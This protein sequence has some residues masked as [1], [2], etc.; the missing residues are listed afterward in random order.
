MDYTKLPR[1]LIYKNR[2]DLK[3][4]GVQTPDTMNYLLFMY[5]KQ[6]ALMGVPGA[7]EVALKCYNNAYYICTIIL[8][9][10]NDF[11]ELRISDYVD[12]ILE[13][14]K[15]NKYTDEVCLASMAMACLLLARYD[16]KYG[17]NS[18]IWKAIYHRCTHYQWYH[19]PTTE[20]FLNM[21]SLEYSFSFP[22]S[23][24]EFEPRNI[25]EAI[26]EASPLD[27]A[28]GHKYICNS[29][30]NVTDRRKAIYAA[31]L[32]IS[33]LN[34]NLH[35]I[36]DNYGYNPDTDR[37]EYNDAHV[38]DLNSELRVRDSIEIRKYAV[39]YIT[40]HFPT[41]ETN[42][43]EN[44]KESQKADSKAE[45]DYL[46]EQIEKLRREIKD[47]DDR[48]SITQEQLDAIFYQGEDTI[49]N[50][51]NQINI[52]ENKRELTE[53]V[54]QQ[55][56]EQEQEIDRL[57]NDL[58]AFKTQNGKTRMTASQAAI[59]LLTV[60]HNLRQL[61]NDKKKLTP[62]LE[63]GW[64]FTETTASR[65]L[66]SKPSQKVADETASIFESVSPKLARLIKEFPQTF[67]EIRINKLKAN[68][69][70]KLKINS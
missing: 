53:K 39:E 37:F 43:N 32:A 13:T 16:D 30:S 70:K 1:Q 56:K 40:G 34:G 23:N 52:N 21:M 60:C 47:V 6:Q 14:E 3:D 69:E 36:Y 8:L 45:N 51:K 11:P 46:R 54:K 4:F 58:E 65:A 28:I 33:R 63:Q 10:E 15:D 44:K 68:N 67:D 18:D 26:E 22:L 50:D 62:I 7:R 55:E 27:L 20:I 19:S 35:E 2:N 29:L 57:K 12:T 59:F 31:D 61:P 24:T 25:I 9:E 49:V 48:H 41:K 42:D 17:R 64:G 66:G 38:R 5:L